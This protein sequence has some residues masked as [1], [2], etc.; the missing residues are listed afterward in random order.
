MKTDA[1]IKTLAEDPL[2]AQPQWSRAWRSPRRTVVLCQAH[3][4]ADQRRAL[5]VLSFHVAMLALAGAAPVS[6]AGLARRRATVSRDGGAA[7]GLLAGSLSASLYALQCFVGFR[8]GCRLV[9]HKSQVCFSTPGIPCTR[10]I[11]QLT[12]CRSHIPNRA[13]A[14][15]PTGHFQPARHRSTPASR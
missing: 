7:A 11:R 10:A 6:P 12:A 3:P 14:L 8:T 15:H 2:R 9:R 13:R 1:L 5:A 4:D